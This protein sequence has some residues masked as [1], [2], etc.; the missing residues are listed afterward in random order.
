MTTTKFNR[1]TEYY[2]LSTAHE[3]VDPSEGSGI[4]V[5]ITSESAMYV[6]SITVD[7]E[8]AH[9]MGDIYQAIME[10][11]D[12]SGATS[13]IMFDLLNEMDADWVREN[14]ITYSSFVK[15]RK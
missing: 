9:R 3:D 15:T 8:T 7:H 2:S 14:G 4:A 5:T 6:E 12:G 11:V 1:N 10:S 13:A